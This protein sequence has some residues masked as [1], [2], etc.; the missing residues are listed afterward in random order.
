[1]YKNTNNVKTI[2]EAIIPII[3]KSIISILKID[4]AHIGNVAKYHNGFM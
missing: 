4:T 1:M 3:K 2:I